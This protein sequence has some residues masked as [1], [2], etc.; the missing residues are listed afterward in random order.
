MLRLILS[1]ATTISGTVFVILHNNL[2]D[3]GSLAVCSVSLSFFAKHFYWFPVF[4]PLSFFNG[5]NWPRKCKKNNLILHWS[6]SV[7]EPGVFHVPVKRFPPNGT[8]CIPVPGRYLVRK[9]FRAFPLHMYMHLQN[10]TVRKSSALPAI[11]YYFVRENTLPALSEYYSIP[12]KA[13]F[14]LPVSLLGS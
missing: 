2:L 12:V 8:S 13:I 10:I 9:L 11:S 7:S 4:P 14:F 6:S 3:S 5:D 1:V